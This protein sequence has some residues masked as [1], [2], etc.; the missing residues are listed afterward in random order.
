MSKTKQESTFVPSS[1]MS[2]RRPA[3][4]AL[5]LA[6]MVSAAVVVN[7]RLAS[8]RTGGEAENAKSSAVS[9]SAVV[10]SSAQGRDE[11]QLRLSTAGF[12]PA[13]A[14]H[15]AGRFAIMV[16]NQNVAGQYTLQLKDSNGAVVNEITVQQGSPGWS[17]DLPVGHYTLTESSHSQWVC[18]ITIQ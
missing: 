14:T 16:S 7:G 17:V 15:A 4:I 11:L 5:G 10:M 13:S 1:V 6:M 2:W 9:P 3:I 8:R 18:S 12:D